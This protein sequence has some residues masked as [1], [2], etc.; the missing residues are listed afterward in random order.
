MLNQINN[1]PATAGRIDKGELSVVRI[2]N[3]GALQ[4]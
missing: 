4:V 2:Y 3:L 1:R